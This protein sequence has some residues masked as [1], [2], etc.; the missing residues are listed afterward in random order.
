MFNVDTTTLS[1]DSLSEVHRR[2]RIALLSGN[3]EKFGTYIATEQALLQAKRE[4][5]KRGLIAN[6]FSFGEGTQ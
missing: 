4:M 1:N 2:A 3:Y 5:Q 6:S